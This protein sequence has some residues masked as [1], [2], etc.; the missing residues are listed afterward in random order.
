MNV[1][2]KKIFI[3]PKLQS[4][5]L[6]DFEGLEKEVH[7]VFKARAL[8]QIE[9]DHLSSPLTNGELAE[10]EEEIY[11]GDIGNVNIENLNELD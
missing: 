6:T 8:P 10:D 9:N 4:Y 1:S 7:F 11:D 5:W 2:T 3:D